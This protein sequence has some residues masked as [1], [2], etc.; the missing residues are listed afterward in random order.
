M[1]EEIRLQAFK[2]DEVG[3]QGLRSV[4]QQGYIPGIYYD[5]KGDN[6]PVKVRY[7]ALESAFRKAHS[8][9]VIQLEI[10]NGGQGTPRPVMIWDIQHHPVKD[11]ILHVD[12]FGVDM[13][14][15]IQVEIPVQ[16]EGE[17]Q[18][19]VDGGQLT[20]YH[21]ALLV[22]CLP[23]A[24]PENIRIDVSALEMNENVNIEDVTFP[25]GVVPVYDGEENFAVAG[26]NPIVEAS[27]EEEEEEEAEGEAP[28]EETEE[29]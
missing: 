28:A 8:N 18:G 17:A 4:R 12:F 5:A 15:E 23:D 10:A 2:R 20:V 9:H 6:V 27:L 24:I 25:E 13:S 19:V 29:E 11:L 26:V 14:K 21:E 16:I 22:S 1:S 7:R 3:K